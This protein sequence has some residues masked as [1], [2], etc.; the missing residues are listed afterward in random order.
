MRPAKNDDA[1]LRW[2]TCARIIEK[3]KL[4]PREEDRAE[5]AFD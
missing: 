4:V 5:P 3:N 2:T 1:I